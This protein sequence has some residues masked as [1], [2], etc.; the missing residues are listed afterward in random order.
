MTASVRVLLAVPE[1]VE[2]ERRHVGEPGPVRAG[3][4]LGIRQ[5]GQVLVGS[6]RAGTRR[7][8]L[9][10]R[11]S[12]R[13]FRREPLALRPVDNTALPRRVHPGHQRRLALAVAVAL[14]RLRDGPRSG[15]FILV[16]SSI[17]VS[18]SQRGELLGERR[19]RDAHLPHAALRARGRRAT[20]HGNTRLGTLHGRERGRPIRGRAHGHRAVEPVEDS[21]L[22]PLSHLRP[23]RCRRLLAGTGFDR[24]RRDRRLVGCPRHTRDVASARR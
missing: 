2:V 1:R 15:C 21:T 12:L 23:E 3:R 13:L 6:H 17:P 9:R 20:A 14:V 5:P 19:R 24:V 8:Q 18:R 22:A 7:H 10:E 4:A 16:T 11:A